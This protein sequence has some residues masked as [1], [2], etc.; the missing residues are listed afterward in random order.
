MSV[1]QDYKKSTLS[2]PVNGVHADG[3]E[4]ADKNHAVDI[5]SCCCAV[6]RPEL[7]EECLAGRLPVG[8]RNEVKNGCGCLLGS[9]SYSLQELFVLAAHVSPKNKLGSVAA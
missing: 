4:G 6:E 8:G 7:V 5:S 2:G 9:S 3:V 1:T